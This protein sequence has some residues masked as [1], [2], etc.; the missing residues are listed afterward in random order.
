MLG[1]IR[2][3]SSKKLSVLAALIIMFSVIN[4]PDTKVYA[5]G[6]VTY[7]NQQDAQVSTD[8]DATN[9][10]VATTT[11]SYEEITEYTDNA[12]EEP[13]ANN[14]V[15]VDENIVYDA[16]S[17]I[18]QADENATRPM[19]SY[20]VHAQS[21][22]WMSP[23]R[24]GARAGSIGK[25]KRVEAIAISLDTNGIL[26]DDGNPITGGIKFRTHVQSIGWQNWV[27]A[28][29]G[30]ESVTACIEN[31]NYAGTMGKAKRIEAIEIALTGELGEKY[32]VLYRVHGQSYGWQTAKSNGATAGTI[33]QKKRIEAIEIIIV[34]KNIETSVSL[35]YAVHSQS[36][37]WMTPV[38]IKPGYGNSSTITGTV[39]KSKRLEALT[40]DIETAGIEGGVEYKAHVQGIGWQNPVKN[41]ELAGTSG[42]AKRMEAITIELTGP[43][44]SYYDVYYRVHVQNI[45]WL[46]WAKN[47]EKAGTEKG[48]LRIEALQIYL[49]EA[50][51]KAPGST[52]TPYYNFTQGDAWKKLPGNLSIKVNK[53]MNCI[54]VY[55][56]DVPI[57][58]MVCST[59]K[60]TPIGTFSLKSKW[61][62]KLLFGGVY[63][64][65]SCHIVSDFLFHSVPYDAANIYAL[66][67]S[68]YNQLGETA[69][70]GCIRL[71]TIDAK[72]IYDN[73]PSGTTVIIYNSN[74]PGPLG[75]PSA[76]KIPAGQTW[77]PTDPLINK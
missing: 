56:G 39:G 49:V 1:K 46:D 54:T 69:S 11:D 42:A 47:G 53:Q 57:K 40:I 72:W 17:L 48:K 12:T 70:A 67:T 63:G 73:C 30:G 64:Q 26:G 41:G 74:D 43:I 50:G 60:A 76:E 34:E 25:S 24:D 61:R 22:G 21:F 7:V 65:Y 55:K 37:G 16:N 33:G 18:Y 20:A 62:W 9:I 14:E 59:G 75:K 45:G 5:A 2:T 4:I 44:A 6:D 23:V 38:T 35:T 32:D 66:H 3:R 68:Y 15:A 28:E 31:K 52:K 51:G 19:V 27:Y 10:E 13:I 8:T 58:A 29:T 36:Y 77:D 71:T